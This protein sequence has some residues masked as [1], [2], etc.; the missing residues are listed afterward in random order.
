MNMNSKMTNSYILDASQFLKKFVSKELDTF[1]LLYGLLYCNKYVELASLLNKPYNIEQIKLEAMSKFNEEIFNT[2]NV[3]S[4]SALKML[5]W[6]IKNPPPETD[7]DILGSIYLILSEGEKRKKLGEHYT[8]MDL[9][10]LIYNEYKVEENIERKII[11][12]ACGSGNFLVAYLNRLLLKFNDNAVLKRNIIEKLYG[13]EIIGVDIQKNTCLI[14]KLRLLMLIFK[15]SCQNNPKKTIPI[16]QLDSL[17][18]EKSEILRENQY[19]LVV[20]NPPYLR[21]HSLNVNQRKLYK[22]KYYSAKGKYDLYTLFIEKSIQLVNK[23]GGKIAIVTSDKFMSASYGQAIREYVEDNVYLSKVLDLSAIFPFK[24]AVLS[25][26]YFFE[27]P[28]REVNEFAIWEKV[29]QQDESLSVNKLGTVN[30]G[31]YWR[32]NFPLMEGVIKK[33]NEHPKVKYLSEYI[34]SILVGFQST[35]DSVFCKQITNEFINKNKLEKNLVFPMLRGKNLRR[36]TYQWTGDKEGSDT[37]VLYPYIEKSGMTHRINLED[38]PN[39]NKYLSAHKPELEQRKY[40]KKRNG[41][42]WYELWV[43]RSHNTFKN[44]KILTPDLSSECRFSLD[45]SGFF[46]N[47][48]IYAIR[49]KANFSLDDYKFLLGILNSKLTLFIHKQLNPVHLNSKRFRFQSPIMKRYPI[50]FLDKK[51]TLYCEM[52]SL[53]DNILEAKLMKGDI[54]KKETKVD[55]LVYRIYGLRKEE[56]DIIENFLSE[57]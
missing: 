2:L 1:S 20:T 48:T 54:E 35:A 43:E 27:T 41:K 33:I 36:W 32:Y 18:N 49:L 14:A 23:K 15:Y 12:P 45:T 42:E 13:G 40:I 3:N 53:V 26:V 9:V 16:Y 19:D 22:K 25:A 37:F 56:I 11:D 46:Y 5:D 51:D 7:E 47:G 8:R 34:E 4:L 17:S 24:A 29:V 30:L 6:L 57:K 52:V 38:F 55:D 44:I 21:Y 10:N 28:K 31:S 39:V 50:I